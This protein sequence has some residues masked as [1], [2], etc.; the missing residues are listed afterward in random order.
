[1]IKNEAAQACSVSI[2]VSLFGKEQGD[3]HVSHADDEI[4]STPLVTE[5]VSISQVVIVQF[6]YFFTVGCWGMPGAGRAGE[7]Q[8][9]SLTA[10]RW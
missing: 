2:S 8:R 5:A 6:G 3:V 1:M 10:A 7:R 4:F 9:P